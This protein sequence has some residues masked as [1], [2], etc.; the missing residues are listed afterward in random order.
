MIV[1]QGVG[2]VAMAL[3]H[4]RV[5]A[6][7]RADNAKQAIDAM[8]TAEFRAPIN[9]TFFDGGADNL[10]CYFGGTNDR[11]IV[12]IDGIRNQGQAAA[13]IAGYTPDPRAVVADRVNGFF[14]DQA[15][16]I[17]GLMSSVRENT[18]EYLDFVG[19]SAG[20]AT[21]QAMQEQLRQT[22]GYPKNKCVTFGSPRYAGTVSR[23]GS[24][25]SNIVRWMT[26]G[27]PIPLVP[28]TLTDSPSLSTFLPVAVILAWDRYVHTHG[29]I[30]VSGDGTTKAVHLPEQ[31][32]ADVVA[33]IVNWLW[34]R[35]SDP[36]NQHALATYISYLSVAAGARPLPA[37]QDVGWAGGEDFDETPRREVQR[38]RAR[39]ATAIQLLGHNQNASPQVVP[40]VDLFKPIRIGRIWYVMLGDSIVVTAPIEKR[41]RH[42]A[43]V[44]NDFLRS[45]PKQAVVDA[46]SLASQIQTFLDFAQL[47]ESGFVPQIN[48]R[49]PQ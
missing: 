6:L 33:S 7:L 12:Y 41:A 25:H 24:A 39:I 34:A 44:G 9:G 31:A 17:F 10:H 46:D 36:L 8:L 22:P 1:D 27:D 23:D 40:E 43:R 21:A 15:I 13:V 30:Q 20:G 38:E 4:A 26:P 5:L 35:E 37:Q 49:N 3:F 18:S 14:T 48:T 28:P 11:R 47:P 32:S 42:I 45:L 29:G 19:H 2:N 16:R